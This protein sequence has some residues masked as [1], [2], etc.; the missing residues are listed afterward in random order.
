VRILPSQRE[1]IA[2]LVKALGVELPSDYAAQNEEG[3]NAQ[4][5]DQLTKLQRPK[6]VGDDLGAEFGITHSYL[7]NMINEGVIVVD[8]NDKILFVNDCFCEMYGYERADLLNQLSMQLLSIGE[9]N[10][11]AMRSRMVER[12][13]GRSG[14]YETM[15]KCQDGRVFPVWV[16]GTAFRDK[17]GK[18]VASIGVVTDLSQLK[19][20]ERNRFESESRFRD[21][22]Q[23][24]PDPIF[25]E[26]YD[27]VVLDANPAAC[28][29]HNMRC[30]EL[31]GSNIFDLFKKEEQPIARKQ[32]DE[33]VRGERSKLD[34]VSPIA[35]GSE[36]PISIHASHITYNGKQAVLLVVHD[37]STYK[38]LENELRKSERKYRA[39]FEG[40]NGLMCTHDL[41]GTIRTINAAGMSLLNMTPEAVVD[42]NIRDI[43][44]MGA[45]DLFDQYIQTIMTEK[46]ATGVMKVYGEEGEAS[47]IVF[48][49]VLHEEEG[50]E[51][52][53]I[54]SC[55]DITDRVVMQH[56]LEAANKTAELNIGRLNAALDE[57]ESANLAV[58]KST[59]VKEEFLANMSHEIRTPLNAIIGFT[60]LLLETHLNDEQGEHVQVVNNSSR[61]LLIIVNEILDYSK[62]EAGKLGIES[63]V[64]DVRQ[65]VQQEHR[66]FEPRAKEKHLDFGYSFPDQ[67][68]PP[69]LVGDP[70]RLRQIL[71]NLLNNAIKFTGEG[72]VHLYLDILEQEEKKITLKF[73][74]SD[75]GIGI[76][77]EN[78][79]NIFENFVQAKS[80]TTRE[81]GGT[82][83]GLAIVKRLV[84]LQSGVLVLES[85]L[86]KGAEFSVQLSY[87]ID[88]PKAA[89]IPSVAIVKGRATGEPL[90]ILLAEDNALNQRLTVKALE[91][92]G[93]EV[94]VASNGK[95]AVELAR[96]HQFD[97]VLMDIQMPELDGVA[98]TQILRTELGLTMPIVALT[99]NTLQ[100]DIDHYLAVGMTA[101]LSKPFRKKQLIEVIQNSSGEKL[102]KLRTLQ[103][104]NDLIDLSGLNELSDNDPAFIQEMLKLFVDSTPNLLRNLNAEIT[105]GNHAVI[106]SIAHRMKAS[107]NS[108][109]CANGGDLLAAIEEMAAN[110][111]NPDLM[112]PRF[113]ELCQ[114]SDA[115]LSVL[116]EK[117][118]A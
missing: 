77:K 10:E 94:A 5:I 74:V 8:L 31:I 64:F 21:L 15:A 104:G 105:G 92:E 25:V 23:A 17:Q 40:S 95:E 117:I 75:T 73:R 56:E 52:Y 24:S 4:L 29:L 14:S 51:P 20:T 102:L 89:K 1:E 13:A 41:D 19:E 9:E 65:I 66:L 114:L 115:V 30:E 42:L 6:V 57:L 106:R 84:D 107:Y 22:F 96:A 2:A 55:S 71:D 97:L 91:G 16:S 111:K 88:H 113:I 110:V 69:L 32:F 47:F 43:A 44:A 63:T 36:L 38:T 85:E 3:F 48:H 67:E 79:E 87:Q 108:I 101:H 93:H 86:G 54:G 90:R 112:L 82:G 12:K 58:Q 68:L 99:A 61:Q 50:Q 59:Q 72:R 116:V 98:A 37:V 83:L 53:V 33:F 18:V 76:A 49:N 46:I 34:S 70:Y 27:G 100:R 81:Y 39:F 45:Q 7:I 28:A 26:D 109:G 103:A 60:E 78:Q 62:L 80:S 11:A 118:N 35:D